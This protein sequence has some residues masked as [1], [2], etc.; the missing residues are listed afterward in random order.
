M[1]SLWVSNS[2]SFLVDRNSKISCPNS[3]FHVLI[4][5]Q[6]REKAGPCPDER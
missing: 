3:K 1:S 2:G 4:A 6:S 5:G